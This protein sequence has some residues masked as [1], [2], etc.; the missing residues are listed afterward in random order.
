MPS[1]QPDEP[2]DTPDLGERL[3]THEKRLNTHSAILSAIAAKL[4][5]PM[6]AEPMEGG[7][8]DAR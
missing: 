2:D 4:G 6:P 1:T 3:E 7:D 8:A 5:V